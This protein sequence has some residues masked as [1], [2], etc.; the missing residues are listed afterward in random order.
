MLHC[1]QGCGV[2]KPD[3]I[4]SVP[5]FYTGKRVISGVSCLTW[6]V[7]SATPDRFA[8][9]ASGQVCELYDGGADFTD[10]NPFQWS[11]LPASYKTTADPL[12]MVLPPAC[13]QAA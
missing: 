6:F 4:T 3:W 13:T 5:Y 11:V 1:T 2:L 12:E 8:S 9:T 10:D 7:Q